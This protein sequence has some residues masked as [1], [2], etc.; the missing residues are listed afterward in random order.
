MA[1]INANLK[2]YKN[3]FKKHLYSYSQWTKGSDITRRMVLC[4][5]VECGLKCCIMQNNKLYQS[6]QASDEIKDILRSHN[7]RKLLKAVNQSGNYK[8]PTFKT[9]YRQ[10][11]TPNEFHQICRYCIEPQNGEM[12]SIHEFEKTLQNIIT[13]LEEVIYL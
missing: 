7:F 1:I 4:Y 13:W 9:E 10:D 3:A 11:V 12:S 2:N 8:F 5:C 6:N